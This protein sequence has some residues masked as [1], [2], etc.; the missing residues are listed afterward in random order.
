LDVRGKTVEVHDLSDSGSGGVWIRRMDNNLITQISFV[1]LIG[2][3]AKNAELIVEIA[4][5]Q[6]KKRE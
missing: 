1:L 5:Q 4:K 2:L 6:E 3:S